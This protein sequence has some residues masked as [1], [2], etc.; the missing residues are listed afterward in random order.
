[1]TI[2]W[3]GLSVGALYAAV[4]V[5]Y[6][7]VFVATSTFNFAQAQYVMLGT[8]IAFAGRENFDWPLP[9]ILL[10]GAAGGLIVGA[11]QERVTIK[12]V[13]N[14]G[15][16]GQLVTTVGASVVLQ[17][18]ALEIWGTDPRRAGTLV[19][20]DPITLL[21]GRITVDELYILIICIGLV[22]AVALW[23]RYTKLGIISLAASE[24]P[25]AATIRG[26]N[27]SRLSTVSVG[28]A[29]ALGMVIGILVV[30][31][32]LASASLG[33]TLV[34]K[35]F[36][37]MAIGGFGSYLG[38]LVGG[39]ALGLI[40]AY[41]GFHFGEKW[42]NLIVYGILLTVLMVKPSGLFGRHTERVV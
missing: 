35:A 12:P 11:L 38:V 30:S 16:H 20:Q 31:K 34:L 25:Q 5:G 6:N 37:V 40:E 39:L 15:A 27:V 32:T 23:S 26:I 17:G 8:F 21:G 14:K 1:M 42:V 22:V 3:A 13:A 33:D 9:L 41:S 2:F 19:S 7:M 29:A 10:V 24:N 36:V 18:I 28:A 4:A